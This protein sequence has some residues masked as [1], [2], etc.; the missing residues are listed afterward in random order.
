MPER[1]RAHMKIRRFRVYAEREDLQELF[2]EFQKMF[3]IYYVPTYSDEGP[4]SF[5]D[6]AALADLGVNFHGSHLGNRQILAFLKS[7]SCSWKEYRWSD[8]EK[9]GIRHTSLCEANVERIDIDLNGIYREKAIFPTEISTMYYDNETAKRL[10]DGLRKIARRQSA[11]TVDGYFICKRAYG[12]RES[13]R[14]CTIDIKSP[15]EYD[16]R[17]DIQ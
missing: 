13:Y 4:V 7:T 3:D 9:G 10:Y 5:Q 17:V 14:F 2:Q 12:N 1:K 6:V 11:R 16:L 8:Q 15:K